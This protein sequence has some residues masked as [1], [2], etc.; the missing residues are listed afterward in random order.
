MTMKVKELSEEMLCRQQEYI[1]AVAELNQG[2]NPTAFVDTYGCQQNE[3][4]SE[5][6]RGILQEMG[7]TQVSDENDA[8]LIV[9]NSCAVRE[10][11]EQRVLGNVGQL[12]HVKRKRDCVIAVCGCMV[13][14][15]AMAEK[16]KKSYRHVNL[17]F[18]VHA[19][20]RFPELLHRTLTTGKR[21]FDIEQSDGAI[22]EGLPVLRKDTTKAWVSIMYGCNNFCTY[23][24]VPYVRGR[25]RSR[26][27]QKIVDEVTR[28]V[29]AGCRD[30]TLLG[31]NVN[32]YGNDLD[33]DIDFSGL[34]ELIN[35]IPGDF[36][37]RFMTS[38]PK[39]ATP[40]L[41]DTMAKC[42]KVANHIHLPFQSGSDRILGLM[43]RRYDSTKYRELV[44]YARSKMP[45]ISVTSD[46]IVG[47]PGETDEDFEGTMQLVRDIGFDGLF[48]FIY[49]KRSG[50]PAAEM[51]DPIPRSEKVARF[52]RLFDLQDEITAKKSEGLL[53]AEVEVLV[54]AVQEEQDGYNLLARCESNRPVYV[55]G[56][57]SLVGTFTKAK[58]SDSSKWGMYGE[59]V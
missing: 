2:K 35:A 37:I 1:Q 9:I 23:C 41:F 43:N 12:I 45:D 28:L 11:A 57:K 29:E 10:H 18:G 20:P 38:H 3:A 15:P 47:F 4:D 55:K 26:D 51:E 58:I 5:I 32:S 25:E 14:Q 33:A 49:S 19:L 46:V 53:G 21:V 24:I 7:Y 16:I 42:E 59:L 50:T 17:V 30:V 54:E 56:E 36:R 48:V 44:A 34:L 27:P 22:A 40:R 8:D 6:I 31:Q 39:D 13:Q 52:Q